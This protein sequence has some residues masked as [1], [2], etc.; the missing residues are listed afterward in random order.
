[1]QAA[2]H[3]VAAAVAELAARVQDGEHDLDGRLALLLHHRDR[4]AA[5]V[6]DDGDRVV[7]VDRDVDRVAV[8]RQ[9]LVDRVVDDLVDQVVQAAHTGRAD[10]HARPLAHGL[11]ALEDG[12]VLGVVAGAR[13]LVLSGSSAK[14]SSVSRTNDA[15][16]A[17]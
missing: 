3:L 10:V 13:S 17:G 11:E 16:A 4:D 2:G 6:V 7:G 15:P 5:A 8:A 9:R 1:M 14:V 12:D